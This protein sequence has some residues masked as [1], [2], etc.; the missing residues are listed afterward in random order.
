MQNE[1]RHYHIL[2]RRAAPLADVIMANLVLHHF[3]DE[4][5]RKL[6]SLVQES[7]SLFLALEPRRSQVPLAVSRGVRLIGCN[8]V[9]RHDAPA[10]V[11]AGFAGSE[12]S[13]LWPDKETWVLEERP[14]GL[15]SHLFV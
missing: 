6:F 2:Q 4:A 14:A 3:S 5:I 9:T 13:A 8:A 10:S 15:F 11:A 1:V 7:T 12:L